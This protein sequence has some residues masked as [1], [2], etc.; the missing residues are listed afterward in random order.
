MISVV[1]CCKHSATYANINQSWEHKHAL[2][3]VTAA[4]RYTVTRATF[5]NQTDYA[6]IKVNFKPQILRF[7]CLLN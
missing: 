5:K 7:G 2:L 4:L 1:H 3:L 6:D